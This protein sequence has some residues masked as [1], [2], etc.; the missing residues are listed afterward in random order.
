MTK[1]DFKRMKLDMREAKNKA[2]ETNTQ[3]L[4]KEMDAVAREKEE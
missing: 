1:A 3:R 2:I 4:E